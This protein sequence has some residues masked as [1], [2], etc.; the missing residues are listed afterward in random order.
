[1]AVGPE[2]LAAHSVSRTTQR[3][4][5]YEYQEEWL[6]VLEGTVTVST[7]EG[8][9]TLDR[10]DIVSFPPGPEGA[11]KVTNA[12]GGTMLHR[13]DALGPPRRSLRGRRGEASASRL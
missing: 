6:L 7:P 13:R 11:H 12:D 10:G 2:P 8:V 9:D 5:V 1:M 4:D 3:P